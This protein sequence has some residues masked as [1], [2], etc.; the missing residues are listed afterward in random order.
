MTW[1][2]RRPSTA[3]GEVEKRWMTEAKVGPEIAILCRGSSSM[4]GGSTREREREMDDQRRVK[5]FSSAKGRDLSL[6]CSGETHG[7]PLLWRPKGR[8]IET[9]N[10][11]NNG[12]DLLI[13]QFFSSIKRQKQHT[14]I[15]LRKIPIIY[16]ILLKYLLLILFCK[17]IYI[18]IYCKFSL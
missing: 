5:F 13:S 16:I 2:K 8:R 6:L 4:A 12:V 7:I 10:L 15:F 14:K 11:E 18:Y 3:P 9:M 1:P 17:F